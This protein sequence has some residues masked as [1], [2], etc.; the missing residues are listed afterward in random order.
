[1][2]KE[3]AIMDRLTWRV[4]QRVSRKDTQERGTISEANNQIKVEWDRGRTSYYHRKTPANIELIKVD[5][6]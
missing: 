4:G 1:M 6:E 5:S 2:A 3:K